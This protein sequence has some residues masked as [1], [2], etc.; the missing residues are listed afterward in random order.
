VAE[1]SLSALV[2]RGLATRVEGDGDVI[3]RGIRHDSR[4]VEAGDLFVALA[5]TQ[6]DGAEFARDAV[7][8]GAVA[9]VAEQPVDT[10]VPTL[11]VDD[12]LRALAGIARLI[13]DD[14]TSQL[15]VVGITGTNG[16][17]TVAYLVEQM[18]ESLGEAP[19]VIGTV[20]FRGPAGVRPA[21]HTT[22]MAD[23][24]MRL[25]RWLVDSGASHL[26]LEVSSHGIE[27]QRVLGVAFDVV[28]FTN[29]SQ[30]HLDYHGSLDAYEQTKRRLFTDYASGHA[31]I[32]VDDAVGA[33]FARAYA[34]QLLSTSRAGNPDA[35]L[36]V[37]ESDSDRSG[38][39]ARV[40]TPDGEVELRSPLTGAHNLEN[41][42]TA[43]GCGI[44]LGVPAPRV[45]SALA[46]ATGAPGRLQRVAHPDDVL[47]FVD[48]A[49]T[50]DAL[51]KVLTI[52][53]ELTGGRLI[54][55]F[56]CGGD[57][58]RDKRAK[59][60]RA[61]TRR[62]ALA[63]V[64]SDNP[65]SE[66]PRAIL[67]DIVAGIAAGDALEIDE[68]AALG[69]A[70]GFIVVEDRRHAIDIAVAAAR[71]GDTVVIAGKG[72]EKV[73]II[74]DRRLPFDDVEEAQ[75]AISALGEVA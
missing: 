32:N 4:A 57:R 14:P 70:D 18:L 50:P 63:V 64:T 5:G 47:V 73:Q 13:H 30:D 10:P 8:R 52:C 11:I 53:E 48:Y 26:V 37:L 58:D 67:G 49:H 2:E 51:D 46:S 71:P 33:R 34:G 60:A 42:L 25:S 72:H 59:M 41:L 7:A 6:Q 54:A 31:V 38:L 16:K 36:H 39:R 29:L 61:A 23:D 35:A 19:G 56:G 1:V 28:A 22:P 75:R 55:L 44:A 66:A 40:Q 15:K 69:G 43:L 65:R 12:G 17:T 3:A 21:T 27:M 24:M 74:G 68:P 45:A 9:I 62:A 20:E